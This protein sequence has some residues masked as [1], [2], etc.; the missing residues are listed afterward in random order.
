M[1]R[2]SMGRPFAYAANSFFWTNTGIGCPA[3][4]HA[5]MGLAICS[6]V[7]VETSSRTRK[8]FTS[9]LPSRYSPLALEPYR[10][11]LT[12]FGP[13][14]CDSPSTN[15]WSACSA[16]FFLKNHITPPPLCSQNTYKLHGKSFIMLAQ[17]QRGGGVT[18]LLRL[19]RLRLI[20][21]RTHQIL[22]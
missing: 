14:A 16:L 5:R 13:S 12:N 4:I 20:R 11:T 2:N 7:S 21:H 1:S 6:N 10:T 3:F 17:T 9:E 22:H 15:S 18:S 19:P 8:T